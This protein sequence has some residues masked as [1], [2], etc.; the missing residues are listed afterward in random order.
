MSK[1]I[2]D[3]CF[4]SFINN[5]VG[6]TDIS[7]I[8]GGT[9]TSAINFLNT[10][11]QDILTMPLACVN[12]RIDN[13]NDINMPGWYSG[14]NAENYPNGEANWVSAIAI[15]ADGN[16]NYLAVIAIAHST[17]RLYTRNSYVQDDVFKWG[18]WSL[19]GG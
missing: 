5:H 6:K 7:H 9:I 10:S 13:W 19:I 16:N 11:K 17:G 14:L 1:I 4:K 15:A 3:D 18:N 2:T 8:G 12:C